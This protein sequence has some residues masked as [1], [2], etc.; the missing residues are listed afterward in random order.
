MKISENK[1]LKYFKSLKQTKIIA[2]VQSLPCR[3]GSDYRLKME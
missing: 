1:I 3:H 2:Q